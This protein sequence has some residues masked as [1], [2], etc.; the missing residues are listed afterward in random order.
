MTNTTFKDIIKNKHIILDFIKNKAGIYQFINTITIN[1]K[2]YI[3]SS[4]K[5]ESRFLKHLSKTNNL[6]QLSKG[7]CLICNAFIKYGYDVFNFKI[8][9]FIQLNFNY[10]LK[11]KKR[12][13]I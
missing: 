12:N 8:L 1:N 11:Q 4:S 3:G 5:L 6:R 9:E 7:N 13:Y 10:S 2:S